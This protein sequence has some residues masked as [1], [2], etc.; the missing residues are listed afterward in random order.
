MQKPQSLQVV[1]ILLCGGRHGARH[2]RTHLE[3]CE[4]LIHTM[5]LD[6]S[7]QSAHEYL[8][9]AVISNTNYTYRHLPGL[10][11][12]D[13]IKNV[14]QEV[15][16][17]NYIALVAVDD[18][19]SDAAILDVIGNASSN[20]GQS[21]THALV[22][23]FGPDIS[24]WPQTECSSRKLFSMPKQ[25]AS[26]GFM[27]SAG[28]YWDSVRLLVNNHDPLTRLYG[29]I[30][31]AGFFPFFYSVYNSKV[32]FPFLDCHSQALDNCHISRSGSKS[33]VLLEF[34]IVA[35]AVL[36][37][38]VY[39]SGKIYRL[40][41]YIPS[42]EGGDSTYNHRSVLTD[43]GDN[44]ET[45]SYFREFSKQYCRIIGF[46]PTSLALVLHSAYQCVATQSLRLA[47]DSKASQQYLDPASE[48]QK[49][50]LGTLFATETDRI[51]LLSLRRFI[52]D[53]K[54]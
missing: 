20:G 27:L 33:G 48:Y 34:L 29:L 16:G 10:S 43:W 53:W 7:E 8:R 36:A 39:V 45:L 6:S 40:N 1:R 14:E 51:K 37:A 21:Y 3:C 54:E 9:A 31:Q 25:S 35:M 44:C 17:F 5:V 22:T 47:M 41:N 19:V 2:I 32:F 50:S 15:S 13:R 4:G 26:S 38:P 46:S 23:G 11:F 24:Y 18:L 12:Y 30:N 28:E 42:S 49:T 52:N